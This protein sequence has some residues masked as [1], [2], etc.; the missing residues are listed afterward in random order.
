MYVNNNNISGIEISDDALEMLEKV[1]HRNLVPL[2]C[3]LDMCVLMGGL[4]Y[5]HP[6]F[7]SIMSDWFERA[8]SYTLDGFIDYC[9]TWLAAH[10][11]AAAQSA[12]LERAESLGVE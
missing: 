6:V 2:P 7:G 10:G 8:G 1:S 3:A 11:S 9:G 12:D 5:E 4:F